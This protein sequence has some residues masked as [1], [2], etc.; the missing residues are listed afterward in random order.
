MGIQPVKQYNN[1]N[2]KFKGQLE[3]VTTSRYVYV[4]KYILELRIQIKSNNRMVLSY[5]TCTII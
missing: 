4:F 3:L 1:N 5:I 2:T